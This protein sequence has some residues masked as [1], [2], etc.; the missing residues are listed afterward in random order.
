MAGSRN[1]NK[2][3]FQPKADHHQMCALSY[4]RMILTLT[5]DPMTLILTLDLDVI[6]TYLLTKMKFLGKVF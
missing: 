1:N 6:K 5:F 2:I 4:A 3:A